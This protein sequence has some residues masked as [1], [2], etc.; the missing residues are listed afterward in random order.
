MTRILD[1]GTGTGATARGVLSVRPGARLVGIDKSPDMLA[2]AR[3][4]LPPG[5]DLRVG[6]VEDPLPAGPFDLVASALAVHH[7][8]ASVKAELFRRI[9]RILAPAGR[10][11]L[12]DLI[13]P[14]DPDDAVTSIDG[15]YDTPSSL[16][17]QLSWL[18]DAG[19]V[20]TT[21]WLERNLCVL[22]GTTLP[23]GA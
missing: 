12:G 4:T 6:R 1:L 11:V 14:D 5:A 21:S 2:V 19:L 13:V 23:D 18:P 20:A 16:A 15:I 3:R 22:T 10:F 9:A 7:L 8:Q 17:D